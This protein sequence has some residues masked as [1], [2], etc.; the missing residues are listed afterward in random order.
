MQS[1]TISAATCMAADAAA[2]ALFGAETPRAGRLLAR[3][4]ADAEVELAIW[5][6]AQLARLVE[7]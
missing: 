6:A 3:H 4:A 7:P 1:L 2:T 5:P